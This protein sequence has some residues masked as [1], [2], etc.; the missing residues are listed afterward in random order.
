MEQQTSLTALANNSPDHSPCDWQKKQSWPNGRRTCVT[1][2]MHQRCDVTY[3]HRI[4]E[5][6]GPH[7]DISPNAN[8]KCNSPWAVYNSGLTLAPK[9]CNVHV[10][11]NRVK[12]V[13]NARP[14]AQLRLAGHP[15]TRL[16]LVPT[17]GTVA[18]AHS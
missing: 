2:G 11:L 8:T 1:Y 6:I 9:R 7:R 17:Q 15:Q 16:P 10:C 4:T 18:C 12:H 5:D 3:I 14:L 13:R